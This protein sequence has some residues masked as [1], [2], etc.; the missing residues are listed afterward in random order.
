[1]K[2]LGLAFCVGFSEEARLVA[3][4]LAASCG[5]DVASVCCKVGGLPKEDLGVPLRPWVGQVA[6]NPIEQARILD[7]AGCGLAVLLG[8]CVGHDSLFLRHI[9]APATVLAVKD[10]V[11]A[12]NPIAAVTCPYVRKR[13]KTDPEPRRE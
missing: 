8:L 1:V 13:L 2:R 4:F 9:H 3:D 5:F 10:R 12:H 11:L 7:E 6:C